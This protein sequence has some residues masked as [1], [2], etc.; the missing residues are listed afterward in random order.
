VF[1][2]RA[3]DSVLRV[4]AHDL[5]SGMH[6]LVGAARHHGLDGADDSLQRRFELALDGAHIGLRCIAVKTGAEVGQVEAIIA[7]S[8]LPD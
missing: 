4:E 2:D 3:V 6:P 8:R 5:S 7:H 1:N